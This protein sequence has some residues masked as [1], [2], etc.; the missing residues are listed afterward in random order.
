V[1]GGTAGMALSEGVC[2][3]F[4]HQAGAAVRGTSC[5]SNIPV[6][7]KDGSSCVMFACAPSAHAR[8]E[9]HRL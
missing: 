8:S 5:C 3:T 6:G 2:R 9:G 7:E 4:D 1:V